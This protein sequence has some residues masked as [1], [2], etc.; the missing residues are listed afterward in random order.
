MEQYI[1]SSRYTE[2]SK[3]NRGA[4]KILPI[5]ISPPETV[6]ME[7]NRSCKFGKV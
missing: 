7:V 4:Y 5:V 3:I 2:S 6:H 1:S